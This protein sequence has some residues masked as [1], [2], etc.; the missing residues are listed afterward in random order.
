MKKIAVALVMVGSLSMAGQ[1]SAHGHGGA[2]VGALIGGAVLGAVVSSALNPA[3]VVAYQQPVYA[4]PVYQP[5]PVY[6]GPPP[7]YCYD[8]YRGGY[9]ACG[10]PPPPAQYGYPEPQPGW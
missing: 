9:V 2:V 8:Q 7:G 5:A 10:A 4:Q 3:P 1:A 6:A